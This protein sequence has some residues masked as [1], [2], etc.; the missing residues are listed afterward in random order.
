M[1]K[2]HVDVL[3]DIPYL[4]LNDGYGQSSPRIVDMVLRFAKEN[5]LSFGIKRA[6][7]LASRESIIDAESKKVGQYFINEREIASCTLLFRYNYPKEERHN[8]K[9]M[10]TYTMFETDKCPDAWKPALDAS[11]LVLVPSPYLRDIF[12]DGTTS[13]VDYLYIPI[14]PDYMEK[15]D[16]TTL[17][18]DLPKEF[19]FSFVGTGNDGP[20]R[21]GIITLSQELGKNPWKD[22]TRLKVRSRGYHKAFKNVIIVPESKVMPNLVDFYCSSHAG[23][24]PSKGEGFGLP[25]FETAL[26]GRPVIV[27]DNSSMTWAKELIPWC[28]PVPCTS[29]P[30][31]YG[32]RIE[33]EVGNWGYVN[34]EEFIEEMNTL[35]ASWKQNRDAYCD[36]IVET[37]NNDTLREEF[38]HEKIY[39]KL[40]GHLSRLMEEE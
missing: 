6:H 38:S 30:A 39:T 27:A 23:A 2:K 9:K 7:I 29:G 11:D 36:R 13:Y 32:G 21:K 15:Y 24:Y 18:A 26:L 5:N 31:H 28:I 19:V 17:I 16:T 20:D 14:A 22:G 4:Y 12:N 40:S 3:V 34:W 35:K 10:V 8:A 1:N 33:G 25:Q 37:H